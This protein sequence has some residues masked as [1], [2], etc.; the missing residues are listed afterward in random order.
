MYRRQWPARRGN[1]II[2]D[3]SAKVVYIYLLH[4]ASPRKDERKTA[5]KNVR[6]LLSSETLENN[7]GVAV[8]AKVVDSR[9]I[10]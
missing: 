4:T 6:S 7:T 5:E 8:Y 1:C 2:V 9:R 10:C 3:M